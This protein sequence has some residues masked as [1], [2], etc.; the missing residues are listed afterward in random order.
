MSAFDPL[1]RFNAAPIGSKPAVDIQPRS[2]Q[3][4]GETV[5]A[6]MGDMVIVAY[7]PK[8]GREDDLLALTRTHVPELRRLGFATERPPLAMRSEDGTNSPNEGRFV[9]SP[10]NGP[11][12]RRSSSTV[13]VME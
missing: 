12:M 5:E 13:A 6:G 3:C 4:F 11:N 1:T 8:A 7:R 2:G 10:S 9:V